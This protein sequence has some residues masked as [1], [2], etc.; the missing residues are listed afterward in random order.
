M[1]KSFHDH[2]ILHPRTFDSADS[3]QLFLLSRNKTRQTRNNNPAFP[4]NAKV[5][6]MASVSQWGLQGLKGRDT[7]LSKTILK[8]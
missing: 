5:C 2:E 4:R 3:H 1:L 8:L 7:L 6:R